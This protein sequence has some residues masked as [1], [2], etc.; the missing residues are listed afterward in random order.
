MSSTELYSELSLTRNLIVFGRLGFALNVLT[1]KDLNCVSIE[2]F[3]LS[4][5]RYQ[6]WVFYDSEIWLFQL[7]LYEYLYVQGSK[8]R[9]CKFLKHVFLQNLIRK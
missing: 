3:M 2:T 6:V 4:D 9:K 5:F 8:F 7:D 1:L